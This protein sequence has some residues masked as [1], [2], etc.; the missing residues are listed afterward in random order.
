MT[1]AIGSGLCR[2]PRF[3][4][5]VDDLIGDR[6]A[7]GEP[8][9]FNPE[10]IDQSHHAVVAFVLDQKIRIRSAWPLDLRPDAAIVW[11]K[12]AV[13]KVGPIRANGRV[14]SVPAFWIDRIVKRFDPLDVRAKAGAPADIQ[15]Q[16]D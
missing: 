3:L 7:R 8:W 12:S 14:E 1:G 4:N 5:G 6:E 15:R 10:Q 9:R 2:R 11:L 16:M 13:G